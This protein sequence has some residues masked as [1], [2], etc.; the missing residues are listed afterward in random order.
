MN[1]LGGPSVRFYFR[2]ISRS[3]PQITSLR[4]LSS[5]RSIS[6]SQKVR[7]GTRFDAGSIPISR[8]SRETAQ[9]G[10]QTPLRVKSLDRMETPD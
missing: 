8:G 2:S 10:S 4:V 5:S 3:K 1:A 7:A 6:S 9:D